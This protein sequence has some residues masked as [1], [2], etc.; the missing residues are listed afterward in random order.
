MK[1]RTVIFLVSFHILL[2][3]VLVFK[4]SLF[5]KYSFATQ[6]YEQQQERLQKQWQEL[7]YQ[8]VADHQRATVQKYA[9]EHLHFDKIKP[10]QIKT[11]ASS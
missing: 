6:A 1:R 3:F 4:Q 5:I 11:L 7:Y 10:S 9:Q 8:V 2:L